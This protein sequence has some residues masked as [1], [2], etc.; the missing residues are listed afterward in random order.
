MPSTFANFSELMQQ[1]YILVDKT[2]KQKKKK[3]D[4]DDYQILSEFTSTVFF[5]WHRPL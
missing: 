5:F 2:A 1:F 3:K 4:G